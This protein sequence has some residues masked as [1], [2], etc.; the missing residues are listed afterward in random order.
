MTGLDGFVIES[1]GGE[2]VSL[3]AAESV[4]GTTGGLT[5]S[6]GGNAVVT[7]AGPTNEF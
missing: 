6:I 5:G 2:C 3:S 7:T 1:V 4:A